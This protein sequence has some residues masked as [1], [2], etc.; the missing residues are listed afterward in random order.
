LFL[1]PFQGYFHFMLQD[2]H[3]QG[4][5]GN[6]HYFFSLSKIAGGIEESSDLSVYLS[7]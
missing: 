6:F 3:L 2:C 4:N 1:S 5:V 7:G